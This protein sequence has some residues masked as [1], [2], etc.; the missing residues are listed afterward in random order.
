MKDEEADA[1]KIRALKEKKKKRRFFQ[2]ECCD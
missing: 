2:Y 1:E